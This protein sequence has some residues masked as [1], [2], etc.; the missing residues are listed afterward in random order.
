M[1]L[2]QSLIVFSLGNARFCGFFRLF[3]TCLIHLC[4]ADGNIRQDSY[5]IRLYFQNTAGNSNQN[6]FIL[7]RNGQ[8]QSPRPHQTHNR[9]VSRINTEFALYSRNNDKCCLA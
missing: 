3:R 7:A 4:T 8:T 2:R 6:L 9:L 1:R 5:F